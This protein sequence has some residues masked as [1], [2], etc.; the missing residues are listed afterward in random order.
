MGRFHILDS[1]FG[2]GSVMTASPVKKVVNRELFK[3][4]G[5][6]VILPAVARFIPREDFVPPLAQMS[7][8]FRPY[9]SGRQYRNEPEAK[10]KPCM[11]ACP[12]GNT[13]IHE[14]VQKGS[15]ALRLLHTVHLFG[16]LKAQLSLGVV[17]LSRRH[18]NLI[19][20]MGTNQTGH[21]VTV[22]FNN[23]LWELDAEEPTDKNQWPP[24]TKIFFLD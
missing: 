21:L 11:T 15:K 5:A 2:A 10:V 24:G 18:A 13:E 20:M 16:L 9:F 1:S 22:N 12:V 23:G 4:S 8:S 3:P 7:D 17:N 19:Y 14:A 6:P